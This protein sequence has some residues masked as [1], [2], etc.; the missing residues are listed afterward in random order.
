MNALKNLIPL[1]I[2]LLVVAPSSA[3]GNQHC[4]IELI[5]GGDSI[6][7][8]CFKTLVESIE[9]A[10]NGAITF[11]PSA[12]FAEIDQQLR[13]QTSRLQRSQS[14]FDGP[15][16][17]SSYVIAIAYDGTNYGGSSI[18]LLSSISTGCL[19]TSY[20]WTMPSNWDNRVESAH[21]YANCN[22]FVMYENADTSG[23]QISCASPCASFGLLNNHGSRMD[24]KP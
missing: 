20:T 7:R 2:L 13:N 22:N 14:S 19:T 6:E 24:V 3:Q 8:G 10:T 16:I 18:A 5:P 17:Q 11:A 1:V 4:V 12:T 9:F 21:G 15:V 23:A